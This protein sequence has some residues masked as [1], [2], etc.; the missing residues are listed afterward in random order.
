MS[1]TWN[2]IENALDRATRWAKAL[3][4]GIATDDQDAPRATAARAAA[5][6]CGVSVAQLRSLLQPSRRP[7][8]LDVRVWLRI[9]DAYLAHLRR[10]LAALQVEIAAVERM[11]AADGRYHNLL[12]EAKALV[13]H[14]ED[15]AG[16]PPL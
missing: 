2:Q 3:T 7:K 12:D 8:G 6:R 10:R 14:I 11:D 15:A 13:S 16:L 5:G 1:H 4:E 9:R